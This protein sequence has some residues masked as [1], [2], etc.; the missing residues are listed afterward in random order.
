MVPVIRLVFI[1]HHTPTFTSWRGTSWVKYGLTELQY[2]LFWEETCLCKW[3]HASSERKS[4]M[5]V[6]FTVMNWLQKPVSEINPASRVTWLQSM[7]YSRLVRPKFKQLRRLGADDF[8][9]SV[10]LQGVSV[11][12]VV[13]VLT[14]PLFRLVFLWQEQG[15]FSRF[16]VPKWPSR[17]G[18]INKFM[19]ACFAWNCDPGNLRRNFIWRFVTEPHFIYDSYRKTHS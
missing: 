6:N 12:S 13:C 19:N 7:N 3:N 1:A 14:S 5:R 2:R 18:F 11:I 8:E 16:L 15:V 4:Q 10:S 9:M 17:P